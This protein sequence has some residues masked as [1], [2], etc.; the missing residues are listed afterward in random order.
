MLAGSINGRNQRLDQVGEAGKYF[1]TTARIYKLTGAAAKLKLAPAG[2]VK[3]VVDFMG[4]A[5][6]GK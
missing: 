6:S 2:D 3:D 5:L 1:A 4:R